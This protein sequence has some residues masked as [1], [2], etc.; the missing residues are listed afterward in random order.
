MFPGYWILL[1]NLI[2][3]LMETGRVPNDLTVRTVIPIPEDKFPT[4]YEELRTINLLPVVGSGN[5]CG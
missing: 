2:N 4:K 3:T 5:F 1:L